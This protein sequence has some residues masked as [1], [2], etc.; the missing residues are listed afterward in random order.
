MATVVYRGSLGVPWGFR[1][2]EIL[3]RVG[4]GEGGKEKEEEEGYLQF[5][6][7]VL[8]TFPHVR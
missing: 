6:D 8:V 3:K 1:G 4:E 5:L 2:G 7:Q